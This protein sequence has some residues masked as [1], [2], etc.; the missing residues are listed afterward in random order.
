MRS[1]LLHWKLLS[2]L[3]I[4]P[5]GHKLVK[6]NPW[7]DALGVIVSWLG[8]LMCEGPTC[9]SPRGKSGWYEV[10]TTHLNYFFFFYSEG[11]SQ[12][13]RDISDVM[14]RFPVLWLNLTNAHAGTRESPTRWLCAVVTEA[15]DTYITVL[16]FNC[17][18]DLINKLVARR[19]CSKAPGAGLTVD[20]VRLKCPLKWFWLNCGPNGW[21]RWSVG[22][23]NVNQ[24]T[25]L[26]QEA[27][28]GTW[29]NKRI[30]C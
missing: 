29:K 13:S 10:G 18:S 24:T 15:M 2:S 17:Y 11:V 26:V 7:S 6:V 1:P 4:A 28:E 20:A 3:E 8:W 30:V 23:K 12:Q 22:F 21:R 14:L 9:L 19:P 5:F 25:V 27:W 16:T